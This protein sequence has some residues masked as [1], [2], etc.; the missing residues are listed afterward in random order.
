MQHNDKTVNTK[1]LQQTLHQTSIPTSQIYNKDVQQL[2]HQ[3]HQQ[4]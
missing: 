4:S 2:K 1:K 3:D